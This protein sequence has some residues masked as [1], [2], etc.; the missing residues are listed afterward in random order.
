M[1]VWILATALSVLSLAPSYAQ[2]RK[3]PG[4]AQSDLAAQAPATQPPSDQATPR[5]RSDRDAGRDGQRS[6][7]D[8]NDREIDRDRD[9]GR[10]Y[11]RERGDRRDRGER[12]GDRRDRGDRDAG[13]RDR[14]DQDDGFETARPRHRVKVCFEKDNGDEVCRYKR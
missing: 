8:G 5:D 3:P 6:F 10:D 1:R 2:D 14:D 12:D 7:R 4:A 13:R 9:R 11:D